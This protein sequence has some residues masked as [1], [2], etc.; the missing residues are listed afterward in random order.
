MKTPAFPIQRQ[1]STVKIA[2]IRSPTIGM[3]FRFIFEACV[4]T[5]LIGHWLSCLPSLGCTTPLPLL[6]HLQSH[7]LMK[8]FCSAFMLCFPLPRFIFLWH[9]LVVYFETRFL[10]RRSKCA[11]RVEVSS[12]RQSKLLIVHESFDLRFYWLQNNF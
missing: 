11:G 4:L 10:K 8:L 5:D 9:L 1:F 12:F 6:L 3:I 2:F 7:S